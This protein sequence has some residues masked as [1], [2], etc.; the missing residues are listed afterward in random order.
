MTT[1]RSTLSVLAIA[2]LLLSA[3]G[4]DTA[5]SDDG[6][7]GT[8]PNATLPSPDEGGSD[9]VAGN[10]ILTAGSIDGVAL[11]LV[12]GWDVTLS[13]EQGELGGRAA[14]NGYGGSVDVGNGT[15]VAGEMSWT[16]MGCEPA[17]M[18][19]EQSYL[20]ALSAV[21]SFAVTS[22][23]LMLTGPAAEL[24]F[25]PVAPV[26]EAEIVGTTWVL[27]TVIE[28]DAAS[29]SPNSSAA[30]LTLDA[31]GT[32][33]GSTG[34]RM[35]E[36]EWV[37]AGAQ[38]VFTTLTAIDDPLVGV[39]A[40]ESEQLDGVIVSVLGDGFTVELDG[41]RMTLMSQG[42]EGLSYRASTNP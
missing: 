23:V 19:L 28:G 11:A 36:G 4:D 12:D 9:S 26:P 35:L 1:T 20:R 13:V 8:T 14:C 40:P 30:T 22:G 33:T 2:S 27:D 31:D 29:N 25:G 42:G 6:V 5:T 18:E 41:S 3:C 17:V 38:I 15:F 21:T 37:V 16:E 34:C 7:T 24:R 39:C 10:W 32:L